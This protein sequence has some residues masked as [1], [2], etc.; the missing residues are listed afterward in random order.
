MP[1]FDFFFLTVPNILILLLINYGHDSLF[2]ACLI[3]LKQFWLLTYYYSIIILW[4]HVIS[5]ISNLLF[6]NEFSFLLL[7]IKPLL[8]ML[9]SP[10]SL[11]SR[12]SAQLFIL[13]MW[14][15]PD[16]SA[17]TSSLEISCCVISSLAI[18]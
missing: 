6:C 2:F 3:L 16:F 13:S 7:R 10:S 12:R 15:T 1:H 17:S 4:R 9:L 5:T 14:C 18:Q 11:W 8:F